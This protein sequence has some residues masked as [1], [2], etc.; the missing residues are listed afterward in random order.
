M[1]AIFMLE[2]DFLWAGSKQEHRNQEAILLTDAEVTACALTP[3]KQ[4][5]PLV[6]KVASSFCLHRRPSDWLVSFPPT[7]LPLFIEH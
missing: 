1:E 3:L 4:N 7:G 2:G 6:A 5:F